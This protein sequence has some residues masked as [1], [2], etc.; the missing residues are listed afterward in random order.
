M[1]ATVSCLADWSGRGPG[2]K[3]R[4]P[5][6]LIVDYVIAKLALFWHVRHGL[7]FVAWPLEVRLGPVSGLSPSFLRSEWGMGFFGGPGYLELAP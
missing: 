2:V 4:K 5:D 6:I 7:V 3:L 1:G